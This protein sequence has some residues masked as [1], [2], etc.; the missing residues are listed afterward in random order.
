MVKFGGHVEAIRDGELADAQLYLVPYNKMKYLIHEHTD[1]KTRNDT[2]STQKLLDFKNF[3]DIGA[4][5]KQAEEDLD[6]TGL[7]VKIWKAALQ[8]AENDFRKARAQVW[9]NIFTTITANLDVDDSMV[10]GAHPGNAIMAYVDLSRRKGTNDAQELLARLKEIYRS[11]WV[12]SEALRKLV[13]KSDKHQPERQLSSELLPLLYTSSLYAGQ[14]MVQDSIDIL[15]ELL[16]GE[17]ND[18]EGYIDTS[19][20]PGGDPPFKKMIRRD[21]EER[22]QHSVDIRVMEFN[23][24]KSLVQSIPTNDL[25]PKL[26]SHRG[27]HNIKDRNDKRPVENSLSAYEMAWTCGIELCECDIALTKDE[28]LVLAHDEDFTR[29]A[30]ESSETSKRKVSDLTFKEIISMPLTSGARPPLL[31]DVLRSASAISEKAK[32]VIEI[33]PG[34]ESSAYALARMLIRHPDLRS[35]VAM[36]MSFDVSTMH[37]L[38]RELERAILPD[39]RDNGGEGDVGMP[40]QS[41]HRR[42]TSFDHFGNMS[43]NYFGNMGASTSFLKL[44]SYP[45]TRNF[46]SRESI[47]LSISETNLKGGTNIIDELDR[48][49]VEEP[50]KSLREQHQMP[51]LMLLT[52]ADPPSIACELQVKHNE[53]HRVDN[54]LNTE[55]G[56]LDGVYLQYEKEMMNPEGAAYLR[57]LSKRH[58]V[59]IWQYAERD[60]DD[61]ETFKWLVEE[62]KCTFVNSDLPKSFRGDL[63][64]QR[65]SL[66]PLPSRR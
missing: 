38:R 45:S 29:L 23:W 56:S 20:R 36:I 63:V 31:I 61:F 34:N 24:L 40:L 48:L 8:D 18:I 1:S 30:L 22:H 58:L 19:T 62:G 64:I 53:L 21:S 44:P 7:F 46:N 27:F 12:N 32:L 17:H 4:E 33:K 10:R 41:H 55:D 59:G 28:K 37:Q 54:W 47:G 15:R 50:P 43:V 13:K 49:E 25:L 6:Q 51:K 42:R 26:V 2:I 60:P 5:Q 66:P 39:S 57:Q 3:I 16:T 11:A 52:V 35:S 9:Q 14:T 65:D